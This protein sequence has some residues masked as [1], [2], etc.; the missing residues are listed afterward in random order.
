MDPAFARVTEHLDANYRLL[1]AMAP[2]AAEE[3]PSNTPKGGV[4]LFFDKGKPMYAGRTKR[5][6]SDRVRGH[7]GKSPDCPLAWLL[8][9]EVTGLR[10]TYKEKGSRKDLMNQPEFRRVYE[11]QKERIKKMEIRFVAEADPTRQ[12][13]LEIYTA[14]VSGSRYNDFDCH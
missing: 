11:E 5:K 12:A 2:V 9:R 14:V 7:F 10:P 4:Y 8:A 1:M 6:I 3:I 13:L